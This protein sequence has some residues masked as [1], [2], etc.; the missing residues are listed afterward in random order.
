[1]NNLD[2]KIEIQFQRERKSV[3]FHKFSMITNFQGY[4]ANIPVVLIRSQS[5]NKDCLNYSETSEPAI[6]KIMG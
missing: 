5:L 1:M 3:Y 6:H 2:S 4:R